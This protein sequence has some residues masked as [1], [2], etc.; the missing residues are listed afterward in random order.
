M[1]KRNAAY[2]DAN[3]RKC[4][5]HQVARDGTK[6]PT[7]IYSYESKSKLYDIVVPAVGFFTCRTN[8]RRV[9]AGP[10]HHEID[11]FFNLALCLTT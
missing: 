8:M 7:V 10:A 9:E 6:L 5:C 1:T 11:K 3:F 4:H 2:S